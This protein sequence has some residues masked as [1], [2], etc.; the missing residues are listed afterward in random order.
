M[1]IVF[2]LLLFACVFTFPIL[3]RFDTELF[4][5]ARDL[6]STNY[7]VHLQVDGNSVRASSKSST[8]SFLYQNGRMLRFDNQGSMCVDL[9]DV[10]PSNFFASIFKNMVPMDSMKTFDSEVNKC[11]GEKYLIHYEGENLVV[12]SKNN[13]ISR[14]IGQNVIIDVKMI[15]KQQ[16]IDIPVKIN[17]CVPSVSLESDAKVT[18]T[19]WFDSITTCQLKWL[20]DGSICAVAPLEGPTKTCIFFHGSGERITAPTREEHKDYW[21][22]LNNYTPQ[23]KI[24]RYV[25][26]ETKYRGW[27]SVE[28]QKHY[29]DEAT[30]DQ[31]DKKLITN[32]II[33][34]HSM[35]AMIVAAAIRNGFCDIDNRTSSWYS[36][37][38]PFEGSHII[39]FVKRVCERKVPGILP[40]IYRYIS[41]LF[42]YCYPGKDELYPVYESLGLNYSYMPDIARVG[43]QKIKGSLCGTS[44]FGL[45]TMFS[46]PLSVVAS[47]AGYPEDNDGLVP[48]GS[49][50]II[51]RRQNAVYGND[52]GGLFYKPATNHPDN[53]CR[54]GDGLWGSNRRPCS[55]FTN[56]V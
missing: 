30:Y 18:T 17:S 46:I 33:F 42:G 14:I 31:A 55:F 8:G 28:I 4:I 51:G 6:P 15:T 44:A 39:T 36:I 23:C 53:T 12:C 41:D 35:G 37:A 25:L 48:Q 47:Y 40:E 10:P 54:H 27:D 5:R 21:G 52:P 3:S 20:S 1:K 13:Q 7:T 9:Q 16:K 49:C 43:I 19:S 11:V 26:Q 34:S 56:K 32:K 22:P 29:C 50:K 2:L 24:R 45:T 38:T